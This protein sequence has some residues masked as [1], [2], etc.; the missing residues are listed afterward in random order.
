METWIIYFKDFLQS[1]IVIVRKKDIWF[2]DSLTVTTWT[3]RKDK[4]G[5][6]NVGVFFICNFDVLQSFQSKE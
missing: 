3:T 4:K 6:H 5:T 1:K 2:Q